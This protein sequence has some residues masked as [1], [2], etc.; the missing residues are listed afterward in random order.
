MAVDFYQEIKKSG[1]AGKGYSRFPC[2]YRQAAYANSLREAM[3]GGAAAMRLF[4]GGL[5]AWVRRSGR[6]LADAFPRWRHPT[7]LHGPE[8][9]FAASRVAIIGKSPRHIPAA[10]RLTRW[11]SRARGPV[12]HARAAREFGSPKNSP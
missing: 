5:P 2:L 1:K 7:R 3:E 4:G 8:G 6:N 12:G 11:P 9:Q 10:E